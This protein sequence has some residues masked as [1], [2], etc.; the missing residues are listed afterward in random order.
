MPDS[1]AIEVRQDVAAMNDEELARTIRVATDLAKSGM[2]LAAPGKGVTAHQAFAKILIGRDLGISPT[3]ALMGIDI[4]KG[5]VQLRGVLLASFVRKSADY[6]YRVTEHDEQHCVIEFWRRR[7]QTPQEFRM[8]EEGWELVGTSAFSMADAQKAG[9]VKDGSAWKGH[10]RNMVLWRAM[11]N[12][13][14]W[15]CP[16]LLGGL[17]VYTEADTFEGTATELTSGEG[18]GQPVGWQGISVEDATRLEAVLD[19]AKAV[20][21]GGYSDRATVEMVV[22]GLPHD[23]VKRWIDGAD[24]NLD[25]HEQAQ[26][27]A[28]VIL[29]AAETPVEPEEPVDAA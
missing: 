27:S 10:P 23:V 18:D 26:K 8:Q 28:D 11:S 16:D 9:L 2:F 20:G 7:P 6:D 4:V 21:H 19:R 12:G 24:E 29:D 5:N 25:R 3:Q 15:Y 17:P 1:K 22:N 13:V 14:K